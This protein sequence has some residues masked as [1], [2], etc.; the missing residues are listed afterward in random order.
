MS[1][2]D[3]DCRKALHWLGIADRLRLEKLI[4]PAALTVAASNQDISTFPE[5]QHLSNRMLLQLIHWRHESVKHWKDTAEFAQEQNYSLKRRIEACT[6]VDG[7]LSEKM[8]NAI[9]AAE[10]KVESQ[11]RQ[12]DRR[13]GCK[14]CFDQDNPCRACKN[15]LSNIFERLDRVATSCY[16]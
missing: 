10:K 15:F 1:L 11:E 8:R 16:P 3:R 9:Y 5:V 4:I 14:K 13:V 6:A 12:C 7:E 2:Q